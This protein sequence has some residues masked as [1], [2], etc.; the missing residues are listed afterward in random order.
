MALSA[1]GDSDE[2]FTVVMRPDLMDQVVSLTEEDACG[3]CLPGKAGKIETF[4]A[5]I[6]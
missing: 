5:N 2:E 3:R 1:S 4:L 6:L